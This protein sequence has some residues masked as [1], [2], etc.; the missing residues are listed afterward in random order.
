M[1]GYLGHFF[2]FTPSGR[3]GPFDEGRFSADFQQPL[4]IHSAVN[5]DQLGYQSCPSGLMA[6]AQSGAVVTVKV[7]IEQDVVAPVGIALEFL[8]AAIDGPPPLLVAG[9]D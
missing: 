3:A 6:G 9:E 1:T 7:F 8:C 4:G 5:L 2:I